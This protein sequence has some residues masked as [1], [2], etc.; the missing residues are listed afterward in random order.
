MATTVGLERHC[1]WCRKGYVL[2][3]DE[4]QV[5]RWVT[6]EHVQDVWPEMSLAEREQIISGTHEEC[7]EEMFADMEEAG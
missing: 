2:N 3:L 7:W 5:I 4:D 1:T 6:D